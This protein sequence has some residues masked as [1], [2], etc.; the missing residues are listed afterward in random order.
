MATRIERMMSD[1]DHPIV[2]AIIAYLRTQSP[3]LVPTGE[4]A[5]AV[6]KKKNE[7][8]GLVK[9]ARS[10][11]R[12]T[13]K[14]AIPNEPK[15]AG[16]SQYGYTVTNDPRA[17]LYESVKAGNRADG[18]LTQERLL[19]E[20][21]PKPASTDEATIALWLSQRHRIHA[22]ELRL[23]SSG[24]ARAVLEATPNQRLLNKAA[25]NTE[26]PW[27]AVGLARPPVE[28]DDE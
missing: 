14:E 13:T 28:A 2:Q 24:D 20:Q 18:H 5:L 10:W 7:V 21:T 1:P 23:K 3:R 17:I 12:L 11:L 19:F 27:D 25:E 26:M 22:G 6:N 9:K 16:R 8:Y 15:K 4:I